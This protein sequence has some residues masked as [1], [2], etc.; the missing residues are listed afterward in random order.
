MTDKP[1]ILKM[2]IVV[3]DDVPTNITPTLVAHSAINAHRE[4]N[5]K[6]PLYDEW[7]ADHY[8]KVTVKVDKN[9]FEKIR[10]TMVCWQGHENKTCN[11]E[12][13]CLVCLPVWSDDTPKPLQFAKLWSEHPL[14]K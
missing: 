11:G 13:T 14:K 5:G 9:V 8:F 6:Y 2:Y 1:R 4:F 3:R 12:T 7:L 10:S